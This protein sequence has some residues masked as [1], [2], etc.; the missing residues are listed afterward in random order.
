MI[1]SEGWPC[2]RWGGN[3]IRNGPEDQWF[4][5]KLCKLDINMF[6]QYFGRLL[7]RWNE[8]TVAKGVGPA[9]GF[10]RKV[11]PTACFNVDWM[12]AD[13]RKQLHRFIKGGPT[14]LE[15]RVRIGLG[16]L[17]LGARLN[18]RE[19]IIFGVGRDDA[20][21][22]EPWSEIDRREGRVAIIMVAEQEKWLQLWQFYWK[23]NGI[24]CPLTLDDQTGN[25]W[26]P[27]KDDLSP[28]LP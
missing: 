3:Q 18:W 21:G 26:W 10:L 1:W 16:H 4:L 15:A 14:T 24:M 13:S 5:R 12:M 23:I 6:L 2:C 22:E 25:P 17:S 8:T 9:V 11:M 28:F 20:V 27:H 19:V 7:E